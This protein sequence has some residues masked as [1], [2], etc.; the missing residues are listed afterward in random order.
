MRYACQIWGPTGSKQS[1]KNYLL[2]SFK[3]F[4]GPS[5]PLYNQLKI[6][7]LNNIIILK[8]CLFVFDSLASNLTADVLD[9]FSNL[10]KELHNHDIRE[11]TTVFT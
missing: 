2:I 4:M 6:N 1:F 8:N 7:S 3:H 11:V 9:Q 10:F 5:E